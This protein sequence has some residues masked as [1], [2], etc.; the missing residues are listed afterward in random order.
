ML[1]II[2]EDFDDGFTIDDQGKPLNVRGNK[3]GMHTTDLVK[4]DFVHLDIDYK[5][6]GVGGEDSCITVKKI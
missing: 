1:V 3:R 4:R 6:M 5:Q 2:P